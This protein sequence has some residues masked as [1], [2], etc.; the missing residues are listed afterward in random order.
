M[1]GVNRLS[2]DDIARRL[3]GDPEYRDVLT[4]LFL[5]PGHGLRRV[6]EQ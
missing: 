4:R 1:A 5:E 2:Y 3:N 6:T